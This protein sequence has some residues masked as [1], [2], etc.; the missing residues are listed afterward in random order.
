MQRWQVNVVILRDVLIITLIEKS[1]YRSSSV[2][3]PFLKIRRTPNI[4]S[5]FFFPEIATSVL[6]HVTKLN[7]SFN[8]PKGPWPWRSGWQPTTVFLPGA[9]H[10]QRSLA[11]CSLWGHKESDMTEW[12]THTQRPME[13]HRHVPISH[14]RKLEA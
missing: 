14:E 3:V 8:S 6:W 10:G 7:T 4:R 11:G 9:F 1:S 12:L 13:K 2:T 5:I